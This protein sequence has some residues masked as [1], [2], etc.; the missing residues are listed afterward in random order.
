M[1]RNLI[2]W[3]VLLVCV[4]CG[5]KEE[6]PPA[7]SGPIVNVLDL[8]LSLRSRDAAPSD[9]HEVEIGSA[10]IQVAGQ[11]VLTLTD[12]ILAPADRSGDELPKL[13]E[14]LAKTPHKRL[15]LAVGSSVPYNTVV[16][17]LQTAKSAG[18]SSVSFKV[19]APGSTSNTGFLTLDNFSVRAKTKNDEDVAIP[20]VAARP[21]SD[22][23]SKWEAVQSACRAS[24]T[25]NCAYK[26]E[27]IAEGGN[28]RIV[29]YAAGQGANIAFHRVGA[30][31]P[32]PAP[33]PETKKAKKAKGKKNAKNVD[34]VADV[35]QAPPATEAGFQFRS[36]EAVTASSAIS[37]SMRPVCAASA[38][39]V[40]VQGEKATLFVRLLALIGAS[41]PDGTPAPVIVFE[42]P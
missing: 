30:P 21:W 1:R 3:S 11:Q 24:P 26:P 29:L 8:S 13:K 32:E 27:S 37:E 23:T 20:G 9:A 12:G 6:A 42:L 34:P 36:Q 22:F 2:C 7:P 41:F 10:A 25:G 15:S 35:E 40:V 16:A 39:G 5:K 28:L 31:P 38:C 18:V 4:A 19:R 33:P 17:V 14:A